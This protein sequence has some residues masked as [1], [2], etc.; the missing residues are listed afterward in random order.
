V[1]PPACASGI[2]VGRPV[3]KLRATPLLIRFK[4]EAVLGAVDP[5]ADGARI[6]IDGTSGPGGFDVTI[7]GGTGWA[8]NAAGNRWQFADITGTHGG[9]TKI[10]VR[11]KSNLSP[12]L[13]RWVVKGKTAGS[14]VLPDA[15]GTR[16][17]LVLG[18]TCASHSWNGPDDARPRCEGD[19]TR[20]SCR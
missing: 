6:V 17:T 12:G 10:T 1:N 7:P 5:A 19:A 9:I 4:G 3:L 2:D 18:A 14:L 20:L 16:G 13:I 11:D 15:S 8:V